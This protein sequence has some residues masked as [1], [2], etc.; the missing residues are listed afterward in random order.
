METGITFYIVEDD[1]TDFDY[2]SRAIREIQPDLTIRRFLHG[3]ALLSH[4]QTITPESFPSLIML[5]FFMPVLD[6]LKTLQLLKSNE[7]F[8]QIPVVMWSGS[9]RPED[10]SQ[11]YRLGARAFHTKPVLFEDWQEQLQTTLRYWLKT[12][13]LPHLAES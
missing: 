11:A 5:D 9:S 1:E 3:A 7:S 4:L 8:Q 10:I 6:G 13:E 2:I 12:V